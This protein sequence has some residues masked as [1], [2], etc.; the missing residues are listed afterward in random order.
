MEKKSQQS[1]INYKRFSS[2]D[3]YINLHFPVERKVAHKTSDNNG[4]SEPID[5]EIYDVKNLGRALLIQGDIQLLESHEYKYHESF[6]HIPL[7]FV[8]EPKKV[9][10]L[11]GGDG[12]AAR[13]ILKHESVEEIKIVELSSDVVEMCKKYIPSVGYSLNDPKVKIVYDNACDW[14]RKTKEKFD[15][16]LIDATDFCST[17]DQDSS[18][19]NLRDEENVSFC[20][21]LLSSKGV[22]VYND[23]FFGIKEQNT[24][25]RTIYL[26]EQFNFVKPYKINVP[27][28]LGG[29]YT[30]MICSNEVNLEAGILHTKKIKTKFFNEGVLKSCFNLGENFDKGMLNYTLE[31][32]LGNTV[33]ID[34]V[35]CDFDLINNLNSIKGIM[36]ECLDSGGF[37]ALN[38]I[39]HQFKPQGITIA[40]ILSESHFTCHSW[41]EYGRICFDIFSCA[42]LER[43]QKLVDKLT[44]LIPNEGIKTNRMERKI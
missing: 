3:Q 1:N 42:D 8:R 16:I 17:Q 43:T 11:G 19:F 29:D 23:D 24:I 15:L 31:R 35:G 9:L 10:I 39:S 40:F 44:E 37:N 4:K 34:F 25:N 32:S 21:N 12:G 7:S 6:V 20:Q 13:E 41:P 33:T 30:F 2:Y 36:Q 18:K 26:Q 5:I 22:L 27:Y 38:C 14:I 28:F